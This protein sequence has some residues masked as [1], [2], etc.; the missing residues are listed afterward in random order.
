[1]DTHEYLKNFYER[2]KIEFIVYEFL[3]NCFS[4]PDKKIYK[5]IQ[6]TPLKKVSENINL[7]QALDGLPPLSHLQ[8]IY[9]SY[10]DVPFG[11]GCDLRESGHLKNKMAVSKIILEC[12]SFYKNFGLYLPPNELPDYIDIELEFVYYLVSLVLRELQKG[13][14][15][16]GR[17]LT[18]ATA[19][20][21]FLERHLLPF[22]SSLQ[23]C[24]NKRDELR[25]YNQIAHFGIRFLGEE[26]DFLEEFLHALK[27]K[28]EF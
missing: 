17:V 8:V 11:K 10:F 18:L 2:S 6:E 16:V 13:D 4:Y 19:Q 7:K 15:K 20:K 1:M 3:K 12:K 23:K 22:M 27:G 24:L 14:I 25:F 21:D 28:L 9:T 26:K 5:S